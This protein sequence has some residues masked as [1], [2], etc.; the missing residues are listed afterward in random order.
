MGSFTKIHSLVMKSD[1]YKL[2]QTL[3]MKTHA[4]SSSVKSLNIYW[5]ETY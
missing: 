5:K 3:Y 1:I 4:L 2:Q